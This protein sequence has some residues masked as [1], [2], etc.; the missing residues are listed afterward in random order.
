MSGTYDYGL[1]VISYLIAS[2]AAYLSLGYIFKL[3]Q[4]KDCNEFVWVVLGSMTLGSGIW[5]MHFVGMLAYK[6]EML[7]Q[8]DMSLTI[9]SIVIAMVTSGFAIWFMRK[10][11]VSNT[12]III[13]AVIMAAGIS[14]M[15]YVGME[16]MIMQA[17]ATYDVTIV[18]ISVV[19][20]FVSS[21]AA[22]KLAIQQEKFKLTGSKKIK[23]LA[24]L[25]L[26]VGICGMHY[27]GMAA[28]SYQYSDEFIQLENV[29][30]DDLLV[31]WI[32]FVVLIIYMLGV[33]T[34]NVQN[35][36]S[37]ISASARLGITIIVLVFITTLSSGLATKLFYDKSIDNKKEFLIDNT[38]SFT[39][40]IEAVGIFDLANS[41]DANEKGAK[42]STLTQVMN[43][44]KI[45][46]SYAAGDIETIIM[47]DSLDSESETALVNDING[48][49]Y[50]Y[51]YKH[52]YI[53]EVILE[54]SIEGGSD[55][56]YWKDKEHGGIR[57]YAF[58]A[59]PSLGMTM[60]SSLSLDKY[61]NEYNYILYIVIIGTMLFVVMG[62]LMI[63]ALM[64][65]MISKLKTS[66]IELENTIKERTKDLLISNKS[67]IDEA[68]EKEVAEH[69]L[70]K[71]MQLEEKILDSTTNGILMIDLSLNVTRLNTRVCEIF[72]LGYEKIYGKNI[73]SLL[74]EKSSRDLNHKLNH[75][76]T[77]GV[78][79]KNNEFE[80]KSGSGEVIVINVGLAS[81]FDN[82]KI[83]G[84]VCTI[85][86]VTER[87]KNEIVLLNAKAEAE[88]ASKSKSEFLANMSHEIR[89]PMNGVLGMIN[90]LTETELTRE[91]QE[92]ATTAYNSG[93]LLMSILN[94]IL[95]FSKIEAGKLE[96]ERI[97]FSIYDLIEDTS[98]LLAERA[99]SKN[100][101]INYDVDKNVPR[102]L[103][104]DPTR[105][106]QIII[107]L[108]GNAVKFTERGEII[109]VIEIISASEKDVKVRFSIKDT[110][111]GIADDAQAKIFDAFNQEDSTTTRRFGGTGLGLSICKQLVELMNGEIGVD[112]K[113]GGGSVFWFEITMQKSTIKYE[114]DRL[115]YD[116]D[117]LKVLVI[118]DNET[119][120]AIYKKQL[121][122]W[123]MAPSVSESGK[124][125]LKE[126]EGA[127]LRDDPIDLILLD[128]MMPEMD[129]LEV[130]SKLKK[131]ENCPP[132][133]MLTSMCEDGGRQ[134]SKDLGVDNILTKP[135]KS[136]L[137]LD[138]IVNLMSVRES[139]KI[140]EDRVSESDKNMRPEGVSEKSILLAEDNTVNQ[141]VAVGFLKNMG[142][143]A[144]IANNGLEA[145]E[146]C[147]NK[148]YDLVFMDCQMPEMDGYEG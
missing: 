36:G 78:S 122:N 120:R 2:S 53:T 54:K 124:E 19:V 88:A 111:V 39:S 68:K 139:R 37:E 121:S 10:K 107:N 1:V 82:S 144:E 31:L 3:R 29:V 98:S 16:G 67:L 143:V 20:A 51:N 134:K 89:T 113:L 73:L 41:E 70:R 27:I 4:C 119:N 61:Q 15:H 32:T 40:L 141:R 99:H 21:L 5:A 57:L 101:E 147:R 83:V 96:I 131:M 104:G 13:A 28:V 25:V 112:S 109:T 47:D 85:E 115:N 137:L 90:L 55:V 142:Y 66:K 50:I 97:D 38:R 148:K 60:I 94:D 138:N 62:A 118:D 100:N 105:L 102:F 26:G 103:I 106:R 110:G 74:D 6:M 91:Q 92:Y 135:V 93:E 58:S 22:I 108:L 56:F 76:M 75:V 33:V 87:K 8:Y 7:M 84:S 79:E 130:L 9:L 136:S 72:K 146:K 59:I 129:G 46:E 125:G 63:T 44:Y 35:V 145:L 34:A 128:Y 49:R 132:V 12:E 86:D 24:S 123:G 11:I 127:I 18:I 69:E 117:N 77:K 52:N 114:E 23:L 126:I 140:V 65:P 30:S 45:K 64:N 42:F 81:V 17:I 48:A 43:A 14:S 71:L 80:I 133:I 95:D 116:I